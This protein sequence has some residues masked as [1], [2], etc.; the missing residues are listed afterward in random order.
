MVGLPLRRGGEGFSSEER[1]KSIGWD[2][3]GESWEEG[4]VAG[5]RLGEQEEIWR[6]REERWMK[7]RVEKR[8][9]GGGE[10]RAERGE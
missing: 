4:R 8:R 10:E 9:Q 6:G 3:E 2:G 1:E 5:E 7:G